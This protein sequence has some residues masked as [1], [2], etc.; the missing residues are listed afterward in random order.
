[1]PILITGGTGF[2][3]GSLV[4]ALAGRPL[5]LLVRDPSSSPIKASPAIEIVQGDVTDLTSL[6]EAARGCDTVIHLVAIIEERDGATFDRIIREGTVNMVEAAK[7]ASVKRFVNMSALGASDRPGF[8]YMRA[9]WRAEEAVKS[10]GLDW[11]I[12]RPSVIFGPGDGF[13]NALAGVVRGFPVVPV[14]GDGKTRFQPVSVRDV[15][16]A[17]AAIV[18]DP[19][20]ARQTFELGGPDQ[21]TYEQMLNLIAEKLGKKKPKVHVPVGVMKTIVAVSAPLPKGIQPPVTKEQLKMLALDNTT[22]QSATE[23]LI[24]RPPLGLRDGIDYIVTDKPAKGER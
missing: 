13:V 23:R 10:S 8:D 21:L 5:R 18:D 3:G 22:A 20:T 4:P 16:D 19:M 24:G 2:V 9:K 12:V 7:S 14:V 6:A 1:M 17:F 15:A 11:T